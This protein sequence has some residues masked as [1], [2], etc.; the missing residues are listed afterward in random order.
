MAV[1]AE[2]VISG[3]LLLADA[4]SQAQPRDILV[5]AGKIKTVA[6]P[7]T[8]S[9]S[10]VSEL[11]ARRKLIIPGIVNAHYHSHD[12]LSRGMFEDIPLEVWIALAIM[13][14]TRSLDVRE[15]RIRTLFGAIDCLRNGITTVQDMLGCGPGSEPHIEA[16]IQA[17][18]D[19]GIRCVLGLQ[20]GNRPPIDCLPG[21]REVLPPDLTPLLSGT[22]PSVQ[23]ILDFVSAPLASKESE[24]LSFAIAPGSPQRCSLEL[25]RGLARLSADHNLPLVTHVN[26]SKLQV[27]LAE[28]LY[29]EYGGSVLDYLEVSGALSDRLC[30]AHG[31]WFSDSEIER[32]AMAGAA[33][34]TCPTSNLKL[35]N[36]VA[37]LRKLKHAGVR[38]ALGCDNSSAGDSQNPFEA[39]KLICNL[40]AGKGA[41]D[42]TF[43]ASDA[44]QLATSA[45]ATVLGLGEKLGTIKEG[46]LADVALIDLSDPSYLPLNNPARQIV[47]SESGRGV[48]TVIVNGK[49]VVEDRQ[50][51]T[52]DY[53]N[54]VDE[55]LEL[56][57]IYIHDQRLHHA[58]LKSVIPSIRTVVRNQSRKRLGFNR[59]LFADDALADDSA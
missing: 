22:P 55:C 39:M 53:G 46:M 21:L 6:V 29:A 34:A 38:L 52:M 40:N 41:A 30:M 48:H 19:V 33:V 1:G 4:N 2:F 17:Y 56:S 13:P 49:V 44:L 27:F 36:G 43:L 8:F 20:V 26:E 7:G 25:M 18:D 23:R 3:G 47:Y 35:K 54:L 50:L 31:I 59:W 10:G 37:P 42:S 9:T 57:N 28:E 51:K 15:V 5:S 24:R 14:S 16:A 32:I 58:N 11:D 45:G 12:V